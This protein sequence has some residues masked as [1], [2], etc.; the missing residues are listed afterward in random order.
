VVGIVA[1]C[2]VV[3]MAETRV[4]STCDGR[5]L[6]ALAEAGLR[7]LE[8]HYQ[9][10]NE[11]NV[12]PVPDGDTGTNMLLTMR[13]AMKEIAGLETTSAGKIAD[14]LAYGAMMGSRGNS[15]TILSQLWL[16]FARTLGDQESFDVP[17]MI[18]A[19]R[20]GTDTAYRGVQRP[21]EGTIL[22]VAREMAEEA[23]SHTASITDLGEL[24]RFI[25][26]RGWDAVKRTPD[27]LPVLK[28]AGVVDSG[29]T[30]LMYI[31]EGMLR[32]LQGEP[33]VLEN[34]AVEVAETPEH[35]GGEIEH[36]GENI[37]DVQF[38]IK[39]AGLH[40][41][42]IKAAMEAM[43]DSVV[44]AQSNDAVK[45]HVHVRN[46]GHPLEYAANVGPISDIVVENMLEQ[47]EEFLRQRQRER[48]QLPELVQIEPGQIGVVAVTPG[49]GLAKV[50]RQL[51]VAGLVNGGQTNNPSVE[52][53]LNAFRRLNTD[54]VVVLPNNK[55]IIL[56]AEQAAKLAENM[57]VRV[58]PTRTVP[59]GISA[60][61]SY[62]P[63]GELEA[64][65]TAMAQAKDNIVT[66]EVTTATRN[67]ELDGVRVQEGQIIGL[68]DGKLSVAGDTV[69]NTVGA[70]L[71]NT[72][73][74]GLELVTLYYG[75]NLHEAKAR[76]LAEALHK[77]Y[78]AL[79]FEVIFGGQP[80]YH[81]I[82]S[83]E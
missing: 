79:E 40:A 38:I 48:E 73:L 45:V 5:L 47:Y 72:D 53:F 6:K 42:L 8:G 35:E 54:K 1:E 66:G 65:A 34:Q 70:L 33:V 62:L 17:L 81:Y 83:V 82:L 68:L 74:D 19:L 49:P 32:H 77:Q 29:G 80:H 31:M 64:V 16:G 63:D 12:F 20:V 44:V 26:E 27:L 2:F 60:L 23:E 24:L 41:D 11:L 9:R 71:A 57:Q 4:Y 28:Q 51:G 69:E 67:V 59:Q 39:G 61:L 10:V 25:V 22:T 7:W 3:V 21:V 76:A 36:P 78:P 13:N 14:R 58:I 52:E 18:R 43:G 37:Y 55:N 56:T 46:P 50:F 75:N 15:G 30:G